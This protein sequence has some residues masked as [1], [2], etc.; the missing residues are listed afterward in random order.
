MWTDAYHKAS[1]QLSILCLRSS[2]F[3]L[4]A[5]TAVLLPQGSLR[6]GN[7]GTQI[8]SLSLSSRDGAGILLAATCH[9]EKASLTM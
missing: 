5:C 3:S 1:R 4:E 7:V 6:A 8:L 2:A 9:G